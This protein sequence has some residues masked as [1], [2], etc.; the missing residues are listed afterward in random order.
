MKRALI[1]FWHGL[2]ALLAGIAN[3]FT[4]IL[5]M[6][7]DSKYGKLLRRVVGTCF[8]VVMLIIAFA[9]SV[10]FY[11][12]ISH[13]FPDITS[14]NEY[15]YKRNVSDNVTYYY[16]DYGKGYIETSSGDKTI[17]GVCWVAT[18]MSGDSLVCYSDGKKRGYFNKFTGKVVIEP[19]YRHAWIFS[20]GR[21]AVEVDGKIKF[22]DSSGNVVIDPDIIHKD[23]GEGYV[24]HNKHL[25]AYNYRNDAYGLLDTQG[26]WVLKPEY[27]NIEFTGDSWLISNTEGMSVIDSEL[28]TIIP[29]VNGRIWVSSNSISVILD[30]HVLQ[31]YSSKGEL[32]EDFCIRC[33][34]ML[35]YETDELRYCVT[36][37]Y[38]DDGTLT[39]EEEDSEP[40]HVRKTAKCR[41]YQS[42]YGWYGLI[43]A[44]GKIITM[45]CFSSIEAIGY[46]LYLC[47]YAND[48]GT[49]LNGKGEQVVDKKAMR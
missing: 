32:I 47:K 41:S 22:I 7:D 26:N 14:D 29:F 35:T 16:D 3:W 25:V 2:T 20:D 12:S 10:K 37:N 28:K 30:N 23:D 8:A 9:L 31:T 46:D 45:P 27:T 13:W 39:S 40:T 17:K 1:L 4:V 6:R 43:T 15:Y 5:G 34:E 21:A 38:N 19:K 24:F 18:P 33:V 48:S 42:E 44:E 36:K 49:I 11:R